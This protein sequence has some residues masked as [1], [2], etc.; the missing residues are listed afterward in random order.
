MKGK[1]ENEAERRTHK[2][3]IDPHKDDIYTANINTRKLTKV[4]QTTTREN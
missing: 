3:V 2:Q 1:C 4:L